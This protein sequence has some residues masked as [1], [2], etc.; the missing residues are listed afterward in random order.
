MKNPFPTRGAAFQAFAQQAKPNDQVWRLIVGIVLIAIVWIAPVV[1]IGTYLVYFSAPSGSAFLTQIQSEGS[2]ASTLALFGIPLFSYPA[3]W[4][5]LRLLHGRSIASLFGADRR[6]HWRS[7]RKAAL[8]TATLAGIG[9][10]LSYLG[11]SAIANL[12]FGRWIILLPITVTLIFL[13]IA[14]EELI[15]RGYFMQ[16]LGARFVSRW[17]WWVLPAFLFSLLHYDR[18]TFHAN[19]PLVVVGAFLIGLFAGDLTARTGN[20]ASA[21]GLHFV[22]NFFA[23]LIM[24]LPGPASGLSLFIANVDLNDIPTMRVGLIGQIISIIVV[25]LVYLAI[26]ARRRSGQLQS[27]AV[28]LN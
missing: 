16:Q 11:G 25:Y 3:I 17:V 9:F 6:L 15:F 7:F 5:A 1:G 14:S 8:V 12:P 19:A 27:F 4:L 23:V 20:L 10:F 21:M 28:D 22:N 26:V 24:G 18:A 2:P 13:Q